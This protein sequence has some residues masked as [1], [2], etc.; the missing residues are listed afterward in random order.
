MTDAGA[1][2]GASVLVLVP[3]QI[4]RGAPADRDDVER[5]IAVD[6]LHLDAGNRDAA[7]V[8]FDLMV[9]FVHEGFLNQ[10]SPALPEDNATTSCLPSR[11]MSTTTKA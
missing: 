6:V 7:Q 9:Y 11:S 4:V 5:T 2:A 1:R 10:T 8:E 3:D